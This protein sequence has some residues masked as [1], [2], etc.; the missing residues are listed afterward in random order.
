MTETPRTD[1]LSRTLPGKDGCCYPWED[2]LPMEGLAR[3]LERELNIANDL[4][5]KRLNELIFIKCE[6]AKLEKRLAKP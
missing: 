3:Q 1:A 5:L 6:L 4:V 2:F